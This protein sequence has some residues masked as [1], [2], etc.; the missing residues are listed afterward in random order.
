MGIEPDSDRTDPCIPCVIVSRVV[1]ERVDTIPAPTQR[2]LEGLFSLRLL[3]PTLWRIG[4]FVLFSFE[5]YHMKWWNEKPDHC[6][7]TQ[8]KNNNVMYV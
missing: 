7:F 5:F 6:Q 3:S 4:E 2:Q 1:Q 8:F